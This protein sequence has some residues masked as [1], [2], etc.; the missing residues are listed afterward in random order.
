MAASPALAPA[1]EARQEALHLIEAALARRG[2]LDEALGAPR[3]MAL[4]PLDRGF[5]RAV[6]MAALRQLGPIDKILDG[7][8]K[9]EPPARVRHLLRLGLAQAFWLDTP[10]FAAVD[11]TVA[12]TPQ[13]LRGLVNAI[14]RGA[15][16]D[17]APAVDPRDLAPAWLM[18]R[19]RSAFGEADALAVAAE[20]AKE[21]ATDLTLRAA[22]DGEVTALLEA[23]AIA[24]GTVR[25][26]RRGDVAQWPGYA[27]GR[28]WVQDAA[29]A[30]PA[31]LARGLDGGRALDM[32]AA[33][34]GKTLQLAAAGAKV[35]ALDK[36]AGRLRRLAAGL[37]RTGLA[38]EMIA[39]DAATWDGGTAAFD[40][41]LLDAP[42]SSTGAFRRH[43]DVLWNARP[44]DLAPLSATQARLLTAAAGKV[45]AG[46]CLV[47]SVCSLETEEGEAQVRRFLDLNPDFA[48]DPVTPGEG[49]SPLASLA[50]E[51]WLRILPHHLA[52]GIDGFFIAR[53]S[54]AR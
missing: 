9:R 30:I 12:L 33:P 34:G 16:R 52:G 15:L 32:C 14:M 36:S 31:R 43:P 4:S 24:G 45:K 6:V 3:Y 51:G 35:T 46:G 20:I 2:G 1:L 44:G 23:E 38:A 28:W 21:P 13:P 18:A 42:C 8:L 10:A 48:L 17:G 53:F 5:A 7:K 27:E 47:Y 49:G 39:A 37:E 25:L 26:R 29:A 54:R 40:A 11:T 22:G 19:W 41:V 50:R